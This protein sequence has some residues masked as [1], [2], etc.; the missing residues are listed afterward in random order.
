MHKRFGEANHFSSSLYISH[1]FA[2][3][4]IEPRSSLLVQSRLHLPLT[5]HGQPYIRASTPPPPLKDNSPEDGT[6]N[7]CRDAVRPSTWLFPESRS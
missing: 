7:V 5:T 1:V 2:L 3:Y 4:W 6:C